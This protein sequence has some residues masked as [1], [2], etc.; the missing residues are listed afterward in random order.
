[1]CFSVFPTV[2]HES[3][4]LKGAIPLCNSKSFFFGCHCSKTLIL[5]SVACMHGGCGG[6]GGVGVM[7]WGIKF[8]FLCILGLPFVV[9]FIRSVAF[10]R[11]LVPYVLETKHLYLK[12]FSVHDP[13]FLIITISFCNARLLLKTTNLPNWRLFYINS[14]YIF[15]PFLCLFM[16]NVC[17]FLLCVIK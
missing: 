12:N 16:I 1:M 2:F 8:M 13:T 17:P 14:K 6:G 5:V 7:C 11:Y 15:S 4:N 9:C 3:T 10:Y